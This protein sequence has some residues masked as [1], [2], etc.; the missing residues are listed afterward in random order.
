MTTLLSNSLLANS[1]NLD[2]TITP[3]SKN[4]TTLV[5]PIISNGIATNINN[6]VTDQSTS[7]PSLPEV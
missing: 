2:S 5:P 1:T 3:S 6:N 7:A 4:L